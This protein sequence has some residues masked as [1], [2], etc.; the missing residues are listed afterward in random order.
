[1]NDWAH[2]KV[3]S[4]A[5]DAAVEGACSQATQE[6]VQDAVLWSQDAPLYQIASAPATDW[7]SA[8]IAPFFDR[9]VV[10]P[11]VLGTTWGYMSGLP[12]TF[13][14]G[15][16]YLRHAVEAAAAAHLAN[17][18]GL[19][20]LGRTAARSYGKSLDLIRK[21]LG[22]TGSL[23]PCSVLMA[24]TTLVLYEVG[25]TH[26]IVLTLAEHDTVYIRHRSTQRHVR[27]ARARPSVSHATLPHAQ[28]SRPSLAH[29]PG[30]RGHGQPHSALSRSR[31]R[32]RPTAG[33]L[34][35]ERHDLP[36]LAGRSCNSCDRSGGT[37]V[38]SLAWSPRCG[39][40]PDGAM[41]SRAEMLE[42]SRVHTSAHRDI[43]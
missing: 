12:H 20:A 7:K 15:P 26:I 11:D 8:S 22:E 33:N 19:Q 24:V 42:R 21:G 2:R 17:V 25:R 4:E 30:H 38:R 23:D 31:M 13:G 32:R 40:W 35:L 34:S 18:G 9:F 37:S 16:D 39:L 5:R 1:M 3:E 41:A 36:K 27:S 14:S 28:Q 29:E 43:L 10:Q 6:G